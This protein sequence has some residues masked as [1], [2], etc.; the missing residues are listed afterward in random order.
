MNNYGKQFETKFR[1]DWAKTFPNSVLIRLY[2][3]TNGYKFISGICDF[4]GYVDG[5]LFL[6]ECKSHSGASLPFSV[7][8]QYEKLKDYVGLSG[9]RAGV[10]LW[11]WEKDKCFYIPISSITEL[12][13]LGEKSVGIRHID[14]IYMKE[15]PSVKKRVFLDSDY[16]VL[17]ELPEG[18]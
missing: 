10:I 16:S 6:L 5:K 2:D 3:V 8:S 4:V 9:V 14:K 15:I 13:E 7:I 12:K 11:L 1:Q 17:L 18:G